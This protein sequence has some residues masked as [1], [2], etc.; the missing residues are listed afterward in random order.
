MHGRAWAIGLGIVGNL[1]LALVS[2]LAMNR[3]GCDGQA[4]DVDWSALS[5]VL[6]A[7]LLFVSGYAPFVFLSR[8]VWSRGIVA[9]GLC[10][11]LPLITSAG[12]VFFALFAMLLT[13]NALCMHLD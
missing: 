3:S 12:S 13:S 2:L 8:R 11:A 10:F 4:R 5:G 1:P 7:G 6:A 9:R